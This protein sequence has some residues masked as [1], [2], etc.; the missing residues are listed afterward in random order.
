[1]TNKLH[2]EAL[3]ILYPERLY[4]IP[5]A[6]EPH[7]DM[8]FRGTN[9]KN[10]AVIVNN[11]EGQ[12]LRFELNKL[13]LKI[14]ESI[15]LSENDVAII[16]SEEPGL[17]IDVLKDQLEARICIVFG[18]LPI[19]VDFEANRLHKDSGVNILRTSSLAELD[20]DTDKKRALWGALKS[21]KEIV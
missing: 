2:P 11:P 8:G 12:E 4:R 21:L 6:Q 16:D 10:I 1:M 20:V 13:L 9:L 3:K 7:P 18:N 5:D 17:S 14:L 19:F 15:G